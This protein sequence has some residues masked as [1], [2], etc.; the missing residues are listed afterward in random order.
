MIEISLTIVPLISHDVPSSIT[1]KKNQFN[2][3]ASKKITFFK[4]DNK[5]MV[6]FATLV[7]RKS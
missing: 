7:C 2:S 1:K 5:T 4:N 3:F 6:N